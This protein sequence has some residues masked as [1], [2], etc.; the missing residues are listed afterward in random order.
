MCGRHRAPA[1]S[2]DHATRCVPALLQVYNFCNLEEYCATTPTNSPMTVL[3]LPNCGVK[4]I[5]MANQGGQLGCGSE[6]PLGQC[7][8][9]ADA[10]L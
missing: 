10:L 4:P 6:C 9:W 1:P 7:M 8:Q 5:V 3:Y 2:S